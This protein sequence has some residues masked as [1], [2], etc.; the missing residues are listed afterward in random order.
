MR[1]TLHQ[2]STSEEFVDGVVRTIVDLILKALNEHRQATLL[3]SGGSTPRKIYERLGKG[4]SDSAIDWDGVHLFWGDE[5]CVPPSH[6]DSNYGMVKESLLS[7]ISLP[8][9]NIHRI[10]AEL[11]PDKAAAEYEKGVRQFFQTSGENMPAFDLILLGLGEDGH[12]ASLFPGSTATHEQTKLFTSVF[13]EKFAMHR[14]TATVP[15]INSGA[16][17]MM[18]V[19]GAS[20]AGILNEVLKESPRYYPAQLVN[21]K[22][23]NLQWHVDYDAASLFL[24]AGT[25]V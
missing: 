19:S 18:L 9:A 7:Q 10:P 11:Q 14:V 8:E 16:T 21:P 5:R 13:V 20:K 15:L 6:A 17:V 2:Y 1:G 12:T 3:L 24:T 25:R 4:A 22:S 23:G